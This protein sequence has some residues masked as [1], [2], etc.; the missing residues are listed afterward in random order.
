MKK[1]LIVLT[2]GALAFGVHAEFKKNPDPNTLWTEKGGN[3]V[4]G[5]D[6]KNW[7]ITHSG[8]VPVADAGN[9]VFGGS[10]DFGRYVPVSPEYPYFVLKI[11]SNELKPKS[12][13]SLN[14]GF[15]GGHPILGVVAKV[16]AGTYVTKHAMTVKRDQFL[17]I[18]YYG[19]K[20]TIEEMAM[21]KVPEVAVD[22]EPAV[23]KKGGELILTV[24]LQKEADAVDVKFFKSYRMLKTNLN[25]KESYEMKGD[26]SGKV[27]T[28]KVKYDN[29]SGLKP[30]E[31]LNRCNILFAF[32]IIRGDKTEYVYAPSTFK[33]E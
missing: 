16:P 23:L 29:F 5:K 20:I 12:Y 25:G 32:E 31:R 28:L 9:M 11:K 3:T 14:M 24:K 6:N 21:V 13:N 27:W 18:D 30:G 17:R 8:I 19:Q 4:Y 22:M 7:R 2:A 10:K 26:D 15:P 1:T 33:T